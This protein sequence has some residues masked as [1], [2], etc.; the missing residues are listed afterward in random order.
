[1]LAQTR[2]IGSETGQICWC[3]AVADAR[4]L[5]SAGAS[6]LRPDTMQTASVLTPAGTYSQMVETGAKKAV[7]PVWRQ[8]MLGVLAG[9]C[10]SLG[11]FLAL[12]IS[13]N[14]PALSTSHPGLYRLL[15][16][17]FGF[18][19]GL[20]IVVLS[21]AELFTGNTAFLPLAVIERRASVRQ[22]AVNWAASFSG[23]LA[24]ALL[25]VAAV[26]GAG[27]V[28]NS[29]PAVP[30][31]LAKVSLPFSQAFIRAVMCNWL[32]CMALWLATSASTLG[33]KFMGIWLPISAFAAIG[34][35][36]CVANMFIIPM[37]MVAGAPI[38]VKQFWCNNLL[39]V[40]L[41]NTLGGMFLVA[42]FF[43]FAYGRLGGI[44][45]PGTPA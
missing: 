24:G 29:G 44:R 19:T 11:A 16:G 43:S 14:N 30:V 39:P 1:M 42:T 7:A 27:L 6:S 8:L 9:V 22:L 41:G 40:V 15:F 37:A 17:A 4:P 2:A 32:V 45:L 20:L 12:S 35:E 23:N 3:A 31:A 21:G 33:S 34:L 18:P 13:G 36:H 38:T 5:S 26:C 28:G 25:A 10:V